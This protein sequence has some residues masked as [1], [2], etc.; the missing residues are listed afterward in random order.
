M[1]YVEVVQFAP[2][3][4]VLWFYET[5]AVGGVVDGTGGNHEE[6]LAVELEEVLLLFGDDAHHDPGLDD[7]GV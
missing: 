1:E 2:G 3:G 4:Q 6:P 7:L 5:L